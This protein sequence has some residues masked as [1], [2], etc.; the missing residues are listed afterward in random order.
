MKFDEIDS[1]STLLFDFDG[2]LVDSMPSYSRVMLKI[3]DDFGIPYG[4]DLI[5]V[6]TP[7]GTVKTA[8]YYAEEMG[9]PLT[10]EEILEIMKKEL[11]SAYLYDI[12]AKE[13]V[14]SA[15]KKLKEEGK[16]LSVLTASPHISLDPCLKRLG[17]YDL[18]DNVWSCDDFSLS[19]ADPDLFEKV[20]ESL[21]QKPSDILFFD[22]NL[23]ALTTAKK[24]GFSLCGVEDDA[25]KAEKDEIKE[26]SDFY[27]ESYNNVL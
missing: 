13:G 15:L 26:I 22:D 9:V 7:F 19:K 6:I 5:S 16:S 24:A 12:P 23:G 27:L 20:A 14:L 18:F 1:F 8:E 4:P 11:L 21:S 10:V 25:A 17:L 2:T 3:L